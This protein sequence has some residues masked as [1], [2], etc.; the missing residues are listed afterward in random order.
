MQMRC[1]KEFRSEDEDPSDIFML[2]SQNLQERR[3]NEEKGGGGE[4]TLEKLWLPQ[5]WECLKPGSGRT[6]RW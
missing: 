1:E 3:Q 6:L 4:I 5:F 2:P